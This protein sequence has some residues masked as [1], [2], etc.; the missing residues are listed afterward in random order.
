M[1]LLCT[2]KLVYTYHAFSLNSSLKSFL[3]S[4]KQTYSNT[5]RN[6]HELTLEYGLTGRCEESSGDVATRGGGR[7]V[8]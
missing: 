2:D 5:T 6:M 1:N 3:G 4:Q 7:W 8:N